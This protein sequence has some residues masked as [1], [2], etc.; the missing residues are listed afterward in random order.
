MLSEWA[1]SEL[2]THNRSA[3]YFKYLYIYTLYTRK[4]ICVH[5]FSTSNRCVFELLAIFANLLLII[6]FICVQQKREQIELDT[7]NFPSNSHGILLAKVCVCI[8]VV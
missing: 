2:S 3:H 8:C 5:A 4:Y 7:L 1:V 6:E